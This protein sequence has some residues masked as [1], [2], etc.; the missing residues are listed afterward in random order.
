[1]GQTSASDNHVDVARLTR[2]VLRAF[3]LQYSRQ[4]TYPYE[5]TSKHFFRDIKNCTKPV[6]TKCKKTDGVK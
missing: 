1:M 5:T 3:V 2:R 6:S 4:I